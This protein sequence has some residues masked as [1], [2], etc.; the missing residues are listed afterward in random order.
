M[1]EQEKIIQAMHKEITTWRKGFLD[2]KLRLSQ[3]RFISDKDQ[4][5]LRNYF[6]TTPSDCI[7]TIE[8]LWDS[9][10]SALLQTKSDSK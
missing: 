1:T 4:A 2:Q 9:C 8:E 7:T 10:I 6:M 3:L 5:A